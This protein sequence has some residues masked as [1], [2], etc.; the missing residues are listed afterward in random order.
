MRYKK[1]SKQYF[2]LEEANGQL[3]SVKKY[4]LR[5]MKL[6]KVIAMVRTLHVQ[7][8]DSFSTEV[9]FIQQNKK[10]HKLYFKFFKTYEDLLNIGATIK[11]VDQGLVDFY[12]V[13]E[14]REILLCYRLGEESITHWHELHGGYNCRKPV[15]ELQIRRVE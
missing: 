10:L 4:I 6:N 7:C 12:S 13:H 14:G 9:M 15:E 2:S 5:L 11:D 1:I 3:T 8:N